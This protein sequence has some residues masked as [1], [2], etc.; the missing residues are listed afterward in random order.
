MKPLILIALLVGL[1]GCRFNS[2][3]YLLEEPALADVVG[4]YSLDPSSRDRLASMGYKNFAGHV[5]LNPDGSFTAEQVPACCVHGLDEAAYPFSGGYYSVS[6]TWK[7]AKST[8]VYVVQLT[9]ASSRLV[10]KPARSGA[11]EPKNREAP[12]RFDVHLMKGGPLSLGFAIF[13]GD[14][15]NIVFSKMSKRLP[16]TVD[17]GIIAVDASPTDVCRRRLRVWVFEVASR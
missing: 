4:N 15:D 8:T 5:T 14:F 2:S 7:I 10:D 3:G 12:G 9:L 6:G 17:L 13:N 1:V 11:S 16:G